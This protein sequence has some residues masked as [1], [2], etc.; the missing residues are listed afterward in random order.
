MIPS[1]EESDLALV[2]VGEEEP[3]E[4]RRPGALPEPPLRRDSR[5]GCVRQIRVPV[6]L[7]GNKLGY[8][9]VRFVTKKEAKAAAK[10]HS[11]IEVK[12]RS[13]AW[14]HRICHC[15]ASNR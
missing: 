7:K 10:E 11:E 4:V 1:V 2:F 6:D 5:V 12:V 15:S 9:I 13:S 14:L 8:A 3:P